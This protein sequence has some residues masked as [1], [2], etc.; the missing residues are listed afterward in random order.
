MSKLIDDL[1]NLSRATSTPLRR[2]AIDLSEMV[3]SILR[4][5]FR[6]RTRTGAFD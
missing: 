2:T 5:C 1:L 3:A 4:R 6:P